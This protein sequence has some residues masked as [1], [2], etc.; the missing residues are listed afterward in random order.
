MF[1]TRLKK[2]NYKYIPEIEDSNTQNTANWLY[3]I[4]WWKTSRIIEWCFAKVNKLMD[5]KDVLQHI[6]PEKWDRFDTIVEPW[7]WEWNSFDRILKNIWT[8]FKNLIFIEWNQNSIEKFKEKLKD[9]K[10][11]KIRPKIHFIHADLSTKDWLDLIK[12]KLQDL[13]VESID[14]IIAKAFIHHLFTKEQIKLFEFFRQYMDEKSFLC[15]YNQFI[16]KDIS[17]LKDDLV[18]TT[19]LNIVTDYFMKLNNIYQEKWLKKAKK[20]A[21]KIKKEAIIQL[22][23]WIKNIII[24]KL[25]YFFTRQDFSK[26]PESLFNKFLKKLEEKVR[27]S[28]LEETIEKFFSLYAKLFTNEVNKKDHAKYNIQ[29]IQHIIETL[30]ESWF[31]NIEIV[32]WQLWSKLIKAKK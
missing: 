10:Y 27:V 19:V 26:Y 14:L 25:K 2:W 22:S 32:D 9:K 16:P 3:D 29:T 1:D 6:S 24:T 12:T 7:C 15:I 30:E 31:N 4:R 20:E 11:G 23:L 21:W 18:I 17:S 28:N 13:G 5:N 8:D